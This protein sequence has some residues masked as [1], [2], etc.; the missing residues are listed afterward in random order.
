MKFDEILFDKIEEYLEGNLSDEAKAL[1]E[2][3]ISANPELAEMVDLQRFEQEGAEFLVEKDLR[4][5]LK[6]WESNPPT[7]PTPEGKKN[8]INKSW[9]YGAIA[10]FLISVAAYI[11]WSNPINDKKKDE[12]KLPPPA[13]E[14]AK[15][16]IKNVPQISPEKD[17]LEMI[18]NPEFKD[19]PREIA[20]EAPRNKDLIDLTKEPIIADDNGYLAFADNLHSIPDELRINL[21]S[22]PSESTETILTKGFDAFASENYS[23]V[24]S[25]FSKLK[26]DQNPKEYEVAQDYLAHA[27]FKERE[28]RKAAA[29]FKNLVEAP[30]ASMKI[31]QNEWYLLL[32]LLPNFQDNKKEINRLLDKM[33]TP[34]NY[35][36]YEEE[37]KKLKASI[38]ELNK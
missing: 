13:T 20:K 16:E 29:V 35:H 25:A 32:S 9:I 15:E 38:D 6:N 33:K 18:L 36:E 4:Q 11:L 17:T 24:I 3:E 22:S 31:D 26:Q 14:P 34:D 7:L 37:A 8:G 30:E 2:Q 12:S 23:L 19:P 1:F 27:Y 21:K 28:F 10:L 5:K